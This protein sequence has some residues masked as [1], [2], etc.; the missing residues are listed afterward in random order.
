V[1]HLLNAWIFAQGVLSSSMRKPTPRMSITLLGL[2][3][4]TDRGPRR[5]CI[6]R[7]SLTHIL[8]G[9]SAQPRSW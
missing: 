4:P 8:L 2:S 3:G 5:R 6:P 1:S 9:S 7:I